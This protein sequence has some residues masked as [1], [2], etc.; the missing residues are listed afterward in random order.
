MMFRFLS[1]APGVGGIG[2]SERNRQQRGRGTRGLR[3]GAGAADSRRDTWNC[4]DSPEAM[5]PSQRGGSLA[6][7][8]GRGRGSKLVREGMK[9]MVPRGTQGYARV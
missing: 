6:L 5:N 9:R 2:N 1:W 3:D 4:Q 7:Q 8:A